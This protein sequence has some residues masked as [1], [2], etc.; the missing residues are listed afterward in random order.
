[1]GG[2]CIDE[3]FE[4]WLVVKATGLSRV[5]VPPSGSLCRRVA[6]EDTFSPENG[7]GLA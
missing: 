7:G 3:D 4:G 1:M 6:A 5:F 2:Q